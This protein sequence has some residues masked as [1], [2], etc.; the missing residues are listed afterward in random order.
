MINQRPSRA[1]R[2]SW[3]IIQWKWFDT[4]PPTL[5]AFH[6]MAT[7]RN[8]LHLGIRGEVG[9][10]SNGCSFYRWKIMLKASC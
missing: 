8:S 9:A 7:N 4:F 5:R 2:S 1:G 6:S 10:M 3:N